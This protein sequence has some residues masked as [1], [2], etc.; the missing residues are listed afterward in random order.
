MAIKKLTNKCIHCG[1]P[2]K[3]KVL[4]GSIECL[5][6]GNTFLFLEFGVLPIEH[7]IHIKQLTYLHNFLNRPEEDPVH[8]MYKQQLTN[9]FEGNWANNINKLREMYVL[10]NDEVIAGMSK[11]TWKNTV[12]KAVSKIAFKLLSEKCKSMSKTSSLQ[13]E[14]MHKMQNYL[15]SYPFDIASCAVVLPIAWLTEVMMETVDC[16]VEMR[17]VK[18]IALTV[19]SFL[20]TTVQCHWLHYSETF[21]PKTV[22]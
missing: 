17:K 4:S 1:A 18:I 19:L 2:I 8:R 13:Y 7:E 16:V 14:D 3:S 22:R 21:H 5:Y 15:V 12:K 10:P 11:Y 6:C 9:P 20:A